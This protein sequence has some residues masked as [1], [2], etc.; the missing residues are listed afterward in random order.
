M[1]GVEFSNKA[2][3]IEGRFAAAENLPGNPALYLTE[4]VDSPLYRSAP[5]SS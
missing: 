2:W 4:A 5:A 3:E 1:A